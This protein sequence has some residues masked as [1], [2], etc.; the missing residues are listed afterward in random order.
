MELRI[1]RL[2]NE[3]NFINEL[4]KLDETHWIYSTK[5]VKAYLAYL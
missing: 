2:F 4:E 5:P 3:P 1:P